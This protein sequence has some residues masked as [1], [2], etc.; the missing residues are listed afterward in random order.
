MLNDDNSIISC[1]IILSQGRHSNSARDKNASN[2]KDLAFNPS[3]T[4]FRCRDWNSVV[5][6]SSISS[7]SLLG[8]ANFDQ[9]KQIWTWATTKLF[10]VLWATYTRDFTCLVTSVIIENSCHA[11]AE[12]RI[13]IKSNKLNR[14][15]DR[16]P[17]ATYDIFLNDDCTKRTKH[18]NTQHTLKWITRQPR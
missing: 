1:M 4:Y 5:I 3:I 16:L 18:H 14:Y 13:I 7:H 15:Y 11:V 9:K 2:G 12:K 8:V 6:S 17:Q 10:L